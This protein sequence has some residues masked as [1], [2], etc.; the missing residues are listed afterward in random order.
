MNRDWLRRNAPTV[1]LAASLGAFVVLYLVLTWGFTFYQDTWEFLLNRSSFSVDSLLQPHNE[2]IVVAPVLAQQVLLA[3]FGMTSALP[4]YLLLLALLLATAV[5]LFVYVRR[6][7]GPWV[8]VGAA[9]LLLFAGAAWETVLWPFEICFV[10]SMLFGIAML[11]ALE[12]EDGKG[13]AWA[14]VFLVVSLCFNSLGVA[15][16]AAALVVVA[17]SPGRRSRRAFVVIVP[18]L[19]YGAWYLGYGREAGNEVTLDHALE[20]PRYILESIG[21]ALEAMLGLSSSAPGQPASFQWGR[22]LAI[23][24]IGLAAFGQWR[25]PGFHHRLWPVAAA[26]F[27]YWFLAALN[28]SQAREPTTSRYL[29]AG[30]AMVLLIAANLLKDVRLSRRAL[31]AGAVVVLAAIVG[32]LLVYK[33]GAGYLENQTI[34]TKSN[35]GAMQIARPTIDPHFIPP[36][37]SAGTGSLVEVEAQK[38]FAAIDEYGSP[39]YTAEELPSAP[40]PGPSQADVTLSLALPIET[41]TQEGEYD[42][43]APGCVAIAAG[44]A[45]TSDVE[46]APGPTEIAVAPGPEATFSLRRFAS[47]EFPVATEP[48]AGES[49]TLL[50]IP[51]DRAPQPWHLHVEAEQEVRVC[52]GA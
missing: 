23:A 33:N 11:L 49:T 10:G 25:K 12:R 17:Q 43:D 9:T 34:L 2:H 22:I 28:H 1:A 48:V 21:A 44:Q 32:N 27:T 3:L 7:T 19:L 41:F 5:V 15:F 31:I 50:R 29:Y 26:G 14:C 38:Y 30:A 16:I 52:P 24:A 47:G 8:A 4:E 46:L 40:A 36:P 6:R 35:L 39:A 51:R 45:G 18:A 37:D 42:S 13:D 20:S